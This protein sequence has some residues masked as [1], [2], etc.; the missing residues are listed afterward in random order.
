MTSGQAMF[1]VGTFLIRTTLILANLPAQTKGYV[2]P[3]GPTRC[4]GNLTAPSGGPI[5]S[6]NYPSPYGNN[7]NC[8]WLITVPAG[9]TIVLMFK[10]G[11]QLE[12]GSDFLSIYDGASDSAVE[13]H[14]I[15]GRDSVI[16]V[17]STSNTMFLRFT[18]DK[19]LPQRGFKF[20]YISRTLNDSAQNE[21]GGYRSG[22]SGEILSPNH[23]G[24]Y[25][26]NLVCT[27]T[28]VVNPRG[29]I[30]LKP[31][32][33][34]LE[35]SRDY[36]RVY[37]GDL[38]FNG[39][40]LGSYTEDVIPEEIISASNI[41]S[42]VLT[43]DFHQG[44]TGFKIRFE[45]L[46]LPE[47]ECADPGFP[48]NGYKNGDNF[49]VGSVVTFG[50]ND[51]FTLRGRRNLTC[52]NAGV[53]GWDTNDL[54]V[55]K[56]LCGVHITGRRFGVVYSPF[57]P[58]A[59]GGSMNCTW[60]IEVD[61]GRVKLTPEMFSVHKGDS[62]AVYD[63]NGSVLGKYTGQI[64]DI[65]EVIHSTSTKIRLVFTTEN[66]IKFELVG[67]GFKI[68]YEAECGAHITRKADENIRRFQSFYAPDHSGYI[69]SPN[70]PGPYGNNM[71]CTWTI[72][73]DL[74]NGVKLTTVEFSLEEGHDKLLLHKG[75]PITNTTL[76]GEYTGRGIPREI[77]VTSNLIHLALMTDGSSTNDG[78]KIH[79]QAFLLL[80]PPCYD[81]GVPENGFRVGDKFDVGFFVTF[82]CNDGFT[83]KGQEK[84]NCMSGYYSGWN[85]PLP[86]CEAECGGYETAS[87]H[88]P[89][90][91]YSP[92]YPAPYGN[93]MN[94]TWTIANRQEGMGI[95]MTI[96]EFSL[97]ESR[98]KLSIYAGD[99]VSHNALMGEYSGMITAL[100]I[101]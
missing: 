78:F 24:S 31:K 77:L 15:T 3:A 43:T 98:D 17:P 19:D 52:L 51:G 69:S 76:M 30:R 74:G 46:F 60:T 93:D 50:C 96:A 29:Y 71:E 61:S 39:I 21:C 63:G 10:R 56:A 12:E 20:D 91:I 49:T 14:R 22:Q 72:E 27:W 1:R 54:P 95:K 23:P 37:D 79:Y 101:A 94:C 44:Y 64:K 16:N 90:V 58:D 6:P 66:N 25:D 55:C 41:M 81:P 38:G 35:R 13:L 33:F 7:E 87:T 82:G 4:G 9:N 70:Y 26:N 92:N 59:Y 57:Y 28:I 80:R 53:R 47:G 40:L 73:V 32:I 84:L 97:E 85:G 89:S 45:E 42:L 75:Y 8:E 48:K 5:T 2:T 88:S 86:T 11:Q 34:I 67:W 68:Y 62:L 83:L 18:S 36:L 65:P 100:L 99:H